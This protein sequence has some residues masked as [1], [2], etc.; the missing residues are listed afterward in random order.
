MSV[1]YDSIDKRLEEVF[2]QCLRGE[3]PLSFSAQLLFSKW[4]QDAG[5]P[6]YFLFHKNLSR[7]NIQ[8]AELIS[9]IRLHTRNNQTKQQDHNLHFVMVADFMKGIQAVVDDLLKSR[10]TKTD[11]CRTF[12]DLYSVLRHTIL[13]QVLHG[14]CTVYL[15]PHMDLDL[16]RVCGESG[17]IHSCG[18]CIYAKELSQADDRE[19]KSILKSYSAKISAGKKV[20][21]AVY[22]HEDFDKY[23]REYASELRGGLDDVKVSAEKYFIGSK[24]LVRVLQELRASAKE[25]IFVAPAGD[26]REHGDLRRKHDLLPERTIWLMIDRVIGQ[27]RGH[28]GDQQVLI[29]YDQVYK[30]QNPLHIFDENKPAWVAHT[31]IPHTL[32]GAMLNITRPLWPNKDVA[33]YDPFSGTGT[34]ALEALK[35]PNVKLTCNDKSPIARTLLEDNLQFFASQEVLNEVKADLERLSVRECSEYGLSPTAHTPTPSPYAAALALFDDLDRSSGTDD[36]F[37]IPEQIV[38]RLRATRSTRIKLRFYLALRTKL[39]HVAAFDRKGDQWFGAYLEEV[40]TLLFQARRLSDIRE[41][42]Q[43]EATAPLVFTESTYSKGCTINPDVFALRTRKHN[44]I[45]IT[46]VDATIPPK[47]RF[48]LIVTDPPYGFNNEIGPLDLAKLLTDTLDVLLASLKPEAQLII[49]VPDISHSGRR[50]PLFATRTWITQQVIA[51]AEAQG[52]EAV[53]PASIIPRLGHLFD[54]PYYWNSER[55]LTRAILHFQFRH[56]KGPRNESLLN[57]L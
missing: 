19:F 42:M 29:C 17:Y 57:Y 28:P 32:A 20:F 43:K 3:R 48:D 6:Y 1:S 4:F 34:T 21:F 10:P 40:K 30:N 37:D 27:H 35:F 41:N 38:H 16:F 26:Y 31:T 18:Y 9:L 49:A 56:K 12:L 23:D 39:R 44:R 25:T 50:I 53:V 13:V 2:R 51:K 55:A 36:W 7:T 33:I 47:G 5:T 14:S 11:L 52:F 8:F 54:P 45:S 24:P 15:P 46:A 22:S